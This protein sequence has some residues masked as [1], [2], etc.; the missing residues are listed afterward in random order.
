MELPFKLRKNHKYF[1]I[2][3]WKKNGLKESDEFIE[4]LYNRY[5]V[6]SHCELCNKQFK[7]SQDRCMDHCHKTGKFRNIACNSCNNLKYDVKM[8]SNNTSG[9]KGIFKQKIKKCKQ[10]FTWVFQVNVGGKLKRIKTS[11]NLE[12]LK[13][14]AD[15]WK[16]DNNYNT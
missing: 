7:S 5:I 3:T 15:Q 2:W 16:I 14:W 10:G 11:T 4:E 12:F 1:A 6:A 13:G 8:N 9:Y